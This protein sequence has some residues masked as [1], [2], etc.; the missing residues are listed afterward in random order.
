MDY[1]YLNNKMKGL[2]IQLNRHKDFINAHQQRIKCFTINRLSFNNETKCSLKNCP[3]NAKYNI[4]NSNY[5]WF[6]RIDICIN[7]A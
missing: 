4:N 6:H 1:N 3:K 5:C 7:K 2:I